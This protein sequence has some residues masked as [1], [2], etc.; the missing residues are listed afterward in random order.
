MAPEAQPPATWLIVSFDIDGTLEFGDP[1]GPVPVS[2]VLA[3]QQ[4]GAVVGSASDRLP[5]DQRRLWDG[6]RVLVGFA[7]P[8]HQLPG[9]PGRFPG[10]PLVHIGDG[11]GDRLSARA[12]GAH[13]ISVGECDWHNVWL[14]KK[15][16]KERIQ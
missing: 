12:A 10:Y 16:L 15:T 9:L 11:I 3:V 14:V 2:T 1:P 4:A 7:V 5:S 13:F 8:K 6:A